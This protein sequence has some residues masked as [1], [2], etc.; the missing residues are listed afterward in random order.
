MSFLQ[1]RI[2]KSAEPLKAENTVLIFGNRNRSKDFL[3]E[4]KLTTWEKEQK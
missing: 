1:Q 3:F 4:E 2:A